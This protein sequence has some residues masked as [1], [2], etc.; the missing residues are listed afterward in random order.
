[1]R[2]DSFGK[3]N[4]FER[5]ITLLNSIAN[6]VI[7]VKNIY[8][9]ILPYDDSAYK[10]IAGPN[11]MATFEKMANILIPSPFRLG[12]STNTAKADITV[13]PRAKTTPCKPRSTNIASKDVVKLKSPIIIKNNAVDISKTMRLLNPSINRP[14]KSLHI[15]VPI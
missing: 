1:M 15:M 13:V 11:T 3:A 4:S 7:A 9:A 6:P 10:P 14:A 5:G 8:S 2:L 12:G